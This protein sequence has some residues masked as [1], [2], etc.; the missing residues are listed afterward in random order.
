MDIDDNDP[1]V[2]YTGADWEAEP[3]QRSN[4][5]GPTVHVAHSRP[6]SLSLQFTG[7]SVHLGGVL[8]N[9][10]Q[11]C[12]GTGVNVMGFVNGKTNFQDLMTCAVD[13]GK[14]V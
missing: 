11:S 9:L 10:P 2:H 8:V 4:E 1:Q 3:R 5:K 12:A 6:A 7:R 14:S 13:G